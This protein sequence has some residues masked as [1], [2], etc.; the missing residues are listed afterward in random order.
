MKNKKKTT[1]LLGIIIV[2]ISLIVFIFIDRDRQEQKVTHN[3]INALQN[4]NDPNPEIQSLKT[5]LLKYDGLQAETLLVNDDLEIGY[6]PPPGE[7]I[8]VFIS[9]INVEEVE[10]VAISWLRSRGFSDSDLCGFPVVFSVVNRGAE[11]PHPYKYSTNYLP[12]F[13]GD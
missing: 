7:Q 11:T 4:D 3:L 1:L 5:G 6:L 13:C 9:G 8:A 2:A 12:T 10:G